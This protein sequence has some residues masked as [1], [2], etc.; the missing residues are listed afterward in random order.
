MADGPIV[1]LRRKKA[2][3]ALRPKKAKTGAERSREYRQRKRQN[4]VS[5]DAP[6]RAAEAPV[7]LRPV[8]PSCVTSVTPPVTPSRRHGRLPEPPAI[9]DLEKTAT[10]LVAARQRGIE[11][12]RLLMVG[13][14]VSRDFVPRPTGPSRPLSQFVSTFQLLL[15]AD[16]H[17]SIA[18]RQWCS[19]GDLRS[20]PEIGG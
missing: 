14:G 4:S 10:E 11:V 16:G 13:R 18:S 5:A 15:A 1:P 19:V 12:A 6:R 3:T 17:A 2:K 7:T 8:T 20:P 9:A